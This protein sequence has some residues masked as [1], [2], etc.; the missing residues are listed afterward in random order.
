MF[1]NIKEF[2][3]KFIIC[4]SVLGSNNKPLFLDIFDRRARK[5]IKTKGNFN[6]LSLNLWNFLLNSQGWDVIVDVGSNYGEMLVWSDLPKDAKI[7]AVEPNKH[8]SFFLKKS[9]AESEIN[10]LIFND[11]ISD[12][13]GPGVFNIDNKWSGT[14]SL[15]KYNESFLEKNL[16]KRY[17]KKQVN[18]T[19]LSSLVGKISSDKRLLIKIDV[20]GGE[21]GV[22]KGALSILNSVNNYAIMIE[23]IHLK[24]DE[25][26]WILSNFSIS[27]YDK[28]KNSLHSIFAN[29]SD[30][31]LGTI[32]EENFYEQDVILFRK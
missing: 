10:C 21:V 3:S 20:E 29:T 30:E 23:I 17:S 7:I 1:K 15:V 28:K 8:V 26:K 16:G 2:I 19:T 18:V 24:H 14:S 9:L 27:F 32:K 13:Q 25:I 11:A 31:L 6:D 12:F 5:I 4:R 22:L